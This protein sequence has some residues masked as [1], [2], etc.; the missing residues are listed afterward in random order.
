M[1][2][3]LVGTLCL[4]TFFGLVVICILTFIPSKTQIFSTFSFNSECAIA[5]WH[6]IQL[7]KTTLLQ[8]EKLLRQDKTINDVRNSENR[9]CWT[10]NIWTG[11]INI[12]DVNQPIKDITFYPPTDSGFR[13]GDAIQAL[14]QPLASANACMT[15]DTM[16]P[17]LT[18][19]ILF[20]HHIQ[21]VAMA[22]IWN[23]GFHLDPQM[24]VITVSYYDM[25][26]FVARNSQ[27]WQGFAKITSSAGNCE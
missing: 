19:L 11:C 9:F 6:N 7:G 3:L 23:N 17:Q 25:P 20:K 24:K 16:I 15:Q 22:S 8:S 14:G 4:V 10:A 26:E 12:D 13:L 27:P 21:L 2:R 1:T 5:C 18:I